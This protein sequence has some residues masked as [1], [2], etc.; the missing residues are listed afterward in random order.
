MI[1][2]FDESPEQA[3]ADLEF[4]NHPVKLSFTIA[5]FCLAGRM[6]VQINLQEFELRANDILIVLREPLGN[7]GVWRR[8]PDCRNRFRVR[9]FP[10]CASN[11]RDNVSATPIV[12]FAYFAI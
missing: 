4:V 1:D 7:T 11:R 5:I 12:R 6:L 8:Y 3:N 2:N 9:I 10:D